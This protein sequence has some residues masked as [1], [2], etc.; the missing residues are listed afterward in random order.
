VTPG[1]RA[2]RRTHP[3]RAIL[4]TLVLPADDE[5][6]PSTRRPVTS[7]SRARP[8]IPVSRSSPCDRK[9]TH[10]RSVRGSPACR[11]HD[12]ISLASTLEQPHGF[13][14]VLVGCGRPP[15]VGSHARPTRQQATVIRGVYGGPEQQLDLGNDLLALLISRRPVGTREEI[16]VR[17]PRSAGVAHL[18][19]YRR[20]VIT[21]QQTECA[22]RNGGRGP[23]SFVVSARRY[24][25]G[26]H[27]D[28]EPRPRQFYRGTSRRVDLAASGD[29]TVPTMVGP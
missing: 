13:A 2:G 21:A 29:T 19:D 17:N 27:G 24:R 4:L 26:G 1:S 11:V 9:L 15:L 23:A 3:S 18:P 14:C 8:E 10:P 16:I 5:Q 7:A 12:E 6:S 22:G 25:V 20:G 28:R